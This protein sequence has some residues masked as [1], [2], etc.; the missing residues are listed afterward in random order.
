[1][2]GQF[3]S[4]AKRDNRASQHTAIEFLVLPIFVV[5]ALVLLMLV[6]PNAATW[7]ANAVQAEFVGDA[8][9]VPPPTQFAQPAAEP[10]SVTA[11]WIARVQTAW[12][13][14]R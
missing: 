8:P 5:V 12:R 1:M 11:E 9:S 14:Q 7:I 10:H 2:H 6:Q 13:G 3:E 4:P